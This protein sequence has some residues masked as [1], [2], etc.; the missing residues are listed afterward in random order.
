MLYS[1]LW[2]GNWKIANMML[3]TCREAFQCRVL[4]SLWHV[5]RGWLKS[6]LKNCS[7]FDVQREM[8]KHV[9]RILYCSKSGR[10]VVDAVE[11]FM[12]IYVD[13]HAFIE[14]FRSKWLPKIG[15]VF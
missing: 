4:L 2:I 3:V 9:G 1:E 5:R 15:M 14:H 10:N 11:E 7:N 6:L 13:Q 8:F 12:Q